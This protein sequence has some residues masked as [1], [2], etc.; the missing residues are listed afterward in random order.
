MTGLEKV[1]SHLDVVVY[2]KEQNFEKPLK[3]NA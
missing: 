1:K 2:F 3:L